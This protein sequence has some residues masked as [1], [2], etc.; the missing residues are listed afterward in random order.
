MTC[1]VRRN[2]HR[3]NC[4]PPDVPG[5]VGSRLP[6]ETTRRRNCPP[7][8]V[9]GAVGSRLSIETTRHRI[10][11]AWPRHIRDATCSLVF[12]SPLELLVATILSA[13]C[14]DQR[15]NQVTREL[16]RSTAPRPIMP[17]PACPIWSTRHPEH[18]FFPQ[19][20]QEH[21][22]LLP[23]LSSDSTA[24]CRRRSRNWWNLPAWGENGQRR[25]GTAFGIASAWW[26][27]RMCADPPALA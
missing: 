5:A 9:P 17:G 27:I 25:V 4:P 7:P 18:G 11:G 16:F 23:T 6:I 24:A 10:A 1:P 21:P 19:Q 14:T 2:D 26:S 12:H 20:G 22:G 3:R 15:V 13:Q 8:A